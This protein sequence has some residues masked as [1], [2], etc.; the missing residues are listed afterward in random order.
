MKYGLHWHGFCLLFRHLF[1]SLVGGDLNAN[2]AWDTHCRVATAAVTEAIWDTFKD[3]SMLY[4]PNI[5][6]GP[7]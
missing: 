2:P 1:T 3:T 5:T 7:T 6:M 4:V